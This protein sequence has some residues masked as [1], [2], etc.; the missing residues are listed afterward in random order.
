MSR[1]VASRIQ[2]KGIEVECQYQLI[3]LLVSL[4]RSEL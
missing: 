1:S 4:G 2:P 3:I